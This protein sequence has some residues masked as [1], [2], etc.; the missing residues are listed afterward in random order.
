M[1]RRLP[2]T[3]LFQLGLLAFPPAERFI[4]SLE[5]NRLRFAANFAFGAPCCLPDGRSFVSEK[6]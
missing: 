4:S 3:R 5:I 1:I 2:H 6:P